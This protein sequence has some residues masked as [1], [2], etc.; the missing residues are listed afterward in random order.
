VGVQ[1]YV[2]LEQGVQAVRTTLTNGPTLGYPEIVSGLRSCADPMTTA[3][4]IRGSAWCRG[5]AGGSYVTG[6]IAKVEANFD[7]Y[8]R[9]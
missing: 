2:S 5:C 8:A 7:L 6:W 3:E 4:A 9:L 1:N